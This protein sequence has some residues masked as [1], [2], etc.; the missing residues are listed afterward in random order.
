MS[1]NPYTKKEKSFKYRSF[2]KAYK[3]VALPLMKFLVKKM[4]GDTQAAQ[5][6]FSQTAEAALKGWYTFG[7]K[8]SFFT[9]V[10]R[11]GLNKAADYYRDQINTRSK[12]IYPLFGHLAEIEDSGL[13][14]E[15]KAAVEDLR[16][17]LRECL[18][19][20]PDDKRQLLQFRYWEEMTVKNIADTLGISERAAEGKLYRARLE[21]KSIVVK[22]YPDL[23]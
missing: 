5:E 1:K 16:I 7:H 17:R 6:V 18:D 15:E 8:S 19:L 11:I 2:E 21:L 12:I 20:L 10:C 9:W 14:P 4:G 23:Y 22:K 3:D 13:N